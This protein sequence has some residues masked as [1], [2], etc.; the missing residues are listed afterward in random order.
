MTIKIICEDNARFEAENFED[1]VRAMKLDAWVPQ[2]REKYMEGV[3][4]RC[5]V[6]DGSQIRYSDSEEF[7]YELRRVGVIKA[8]IIERG[9]QQ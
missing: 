3:A 6:W 4:K 9:N 5:E 1:L 7:I 2:S 8:I